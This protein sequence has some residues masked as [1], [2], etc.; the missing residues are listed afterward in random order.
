MTLIEI[1]IYFV[2]VGC[3]CIHVCTYGGQRLMLGVSS[4][5]H[6]LFWDS[7]NHWTWILT[8]ASKCDGVA[9]THQTWLLCEHHASINQSSRLCD[10]H[11][12]DCANSPAPIFLIF[13]WNNA[14]LCSQ[15]WPKTMLLRLILNLKQASCPSLQ[16]GRAGTA[17]MCHHAGLSSTWLLE[18]LKFPQGFHDM[19]PVQECMDLH[20]RDGH[21]LLRPPSHLR[22]LCPHSGN[23]CL[24]TKYDN[25]DNVC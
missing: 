24:C 4:V 1:G 22:L 25:L 3:V 14:S 16:S 12:I 9:S 8:M 7:V 23:L 11:V 13:F 5:F 10:K 17:G 20:G 21:D 19:L 2:F 18:Y 15:G 6:L